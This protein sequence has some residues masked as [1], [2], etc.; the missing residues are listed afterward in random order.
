[1]DY[2]EMLKKTEELKTM[3]E[4]SQSK[5]ARLQ[6]EYF[7]I[8]NQKDELM[9]ECEEKFNCSIKILKDK[10][11]EM[12]SELEEKIQEVERKLNDN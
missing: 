1:M 8:E 12:E 3:I 9:K 4:D 6:G 7:Q 2:E 5:I 11:P 10:I